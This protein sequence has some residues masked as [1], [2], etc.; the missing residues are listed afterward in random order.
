MKISELLA[1]ETAKTRERYLT[2]NKKASVNRHCERFEPRSHFKSRLSLTVRVNAF[3]N[4]NRHITLVSGK[5]VHL[6][7]TSK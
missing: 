3:L 2:Q 5:L 1:L 4:V 7:L 6:T